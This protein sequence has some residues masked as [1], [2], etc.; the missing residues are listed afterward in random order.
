MKWKINNVTHNFKNGDYMKKLITA[1]V[2]G[3]SLV[4]VGCASSGNS[5]LK[6]ETR[7]SVSLKLKKGMT[8]D[9]VIEMFGGPASTGFQENGNEIWRYSFTEQE[10]KASSF[11]PVV[12]MF[13]SGTKGK[14]K[15][16]VIMFDP[17]G[18]VLKHTMSNS[19]VET[20]SSYF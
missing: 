9:Q 16:L 17:D 3:L 14:N 2:I 15:S 7:E 6:E 8:Q 10:M 11:I 1:T 13:D 12:S 18:L 19:D 5:V 4:S 20:K